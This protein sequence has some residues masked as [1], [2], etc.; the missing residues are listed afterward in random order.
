MKIGTVEPKYDDM[1]NFKTKE[2]HLFNGKKIKNESLAFIYG[3]IAKYA[4]K[5]E[6]MEDEE[7]LASLKE[8]IVNKAEGLAVATATTRKKGK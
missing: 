8:Y 3:A 6:C 1:L 5:S 4:W 7:F 2:M